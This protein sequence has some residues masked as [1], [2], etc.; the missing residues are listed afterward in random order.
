MSRTPD[1]LIEGYLRHL[2]TALGDLPGARRRE[3]VEEVAE[4]IAEARADLLLESEAAV[5]NLL[6]RVGD[7]DEIAAEARDRFG[8]RPRGGGIREISAI[9]LLLV[10]GFV[11]VI[12]WFVGVVLLWASEA[13]TT[14]DK[15]IGTFVV[16]L[17]LL[18]LLYALTFSLAAGEGCVGEI[19]PKTGATVSQ[20]CTG[21]PSL[22]GQVVGGLVFVGLLVG[23]L[24]TTAYLARRMRRP[25]EI[26]RS[27]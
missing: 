9:V 8:V 24:F 4:H 14:R 16:P 15:L 20:V 1:D 25:A 22:A 21:G 23:P 12:G 11:L 2:N 10:G 6:E 27:S 18:P 5:R 26:V 17:G 19:D 13:W 7:P 3:V